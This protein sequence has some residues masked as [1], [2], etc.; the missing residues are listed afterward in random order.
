[1]YLGSYSGPDPDFA[2]GPGEYFDFDLDFDLY[3]FDLGLYS[4]N[5][6]VFVYLFLFQVHQHIL[7]PEKLQIKI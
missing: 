6:P 2:F 4:G 5:F 7:P 3:Y 1:M